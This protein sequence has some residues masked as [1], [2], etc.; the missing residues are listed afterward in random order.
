MVFRSLAIFSLLAGN[1]SKS[2]LKQNLWKF[3]W[4]Y[5]GIFFV[6]AF[7]SPLNSSEELKDILELVYMVSAQY[8]NPPDYLVSKVC[9]GIDGVPNGTYILSKIAAGLNSSFSSGGCNY[10]SDLQPSNKSGWDW[11]VFR[12]IMLSLQHLHIFFFCWKIPYFPDDFLFQFPRRNG[13]SEL[14]T[15]TEMVMPIAV[16]EN[17]TNT[18]FQPSP[19]D[20]KNYTKTCQALFGVTPRPHWV[21]TEFG[22]HVN[23]LP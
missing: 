17:D 12:I 15:C 23:L 19:F 21:T 3:D 8:D 2:S 7:L 11:Q 9:S 20:I 10:I 22:G 6:H 13:L 14:Q 4:S 16:G 5:F 18:M 1:Q